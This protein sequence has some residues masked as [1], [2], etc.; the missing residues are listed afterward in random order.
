[1]KYFENQQIFLRLKLSTN[2]NKEQQQQQQQQHHH[3]QK[4][5]DQYVNPSGTACLRVKIKKNIPQ[6]SKK[7]ALFQSVKVHDEQI[8]KIG[9][10]PCRSIWMFALF[11]SPGVK[12]LRGEKSYLKLDW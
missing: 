6:L 7:R 12:S 2:L 4:T 9:I 8:T 5:P 10:D 1:M 11:F 3:Q